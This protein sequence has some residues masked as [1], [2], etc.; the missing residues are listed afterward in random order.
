MQS[1]FTSGPKRALPL[2]F[3]KGRHRFGSFS[4]SLF[5]SF[6]SSEEGNF[7]NN[8]NLEIESFRRKLEKLVLAGENN[9]VVEAQGRIDT[10]SL[11]PPSVVRDRITPDVN[12]PPAPP[13]TSMDRERRLAEI[14]L[15][16]QLE[17]GDDVLQDLWTLWFQER[18]ADA[19][20]L[21]SQAEE[22]SNMGPQYWDKAEMILKEMI[23][24]YGVYWAEPVNRLATLYYMQG[25][26]EEAETLCKMV[27]TIKPWHVGALS[28]I[29][30][31]YASMHDSESARQYAARR[32]P[33]FDPNGANKRRKQWVQQAL[34]DAQDALS[35]AEHRVLEHFGE[36]DHDGDIDAW[37]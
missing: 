33:S 31:V 24:D 37:Q 19:A 29:V 11:S 26:L 28:G 34:Q 20:K 7:D 5:H 21:L 36:R 16:Q 18:G 27:L 4:T 1:P 23:E 30:L 3:E 22:L 35:S 6:R 10:K 32:L 9:N 15:I 13:L 2:S 25:K 14:T 12:L 8:N 17:N